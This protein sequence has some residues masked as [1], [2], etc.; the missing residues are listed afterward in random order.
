MSVR[1][2]GAARA[3]AGRAWSEAPRLGGHRV[4]GL[5][6]PGR[7]GVGVLPSRPRICWRGS[8]AV[9]CG[10]ARCRALW[11]G[12]VR[13]G[14]TATAAGPSDAFAAFCG[15]MK[16]GRWF[17]SRPIRR[18]KAV[19]SGCRNMP[20]PT[21]SR[22]GASPTSSGSTLAGRTPCAGQR[23]RRGRPPRPS[24]TCGARRESA[25]PSPCARVGRVRVSASAVVAR[26]HPTRDGAARPGCESTPQNLAPQRLIRTDSASQA[27]RNARRQRRRTLGPGCRRD[28][29]GGWIASRPCPPTVL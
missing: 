16:V 2:V 29:Q 18:P 23:R 28:A 6:A 27:S 8:P 4:P 24:R 21:S 19:S 12:T 26:N 11:C 13:P 9:W 1:C 17:V 5:L 3:G 15:Q 10:S 7:G 25:A 22:A 20:R 14:C